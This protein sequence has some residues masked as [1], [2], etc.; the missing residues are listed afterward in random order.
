MSTIGILTIIF[1]CLTCI[2]VVASLLF[3]WKIKNVSLY[4]LISV[5]GAV[6]CLLLNINDFTEITKVLI[7]NS[8]INP[9]KILVFFLS[10][11]ILSITLDNLGFFNFLALKCTRLA[12]NNQFK[13]F[14]IFYLMVSVLTIFT[15]NDIVILA[16]VPFICYFCK[17]SK[18]NPTPYVFSTFVAANTWSMTLVI[19]NPTNVYIA[20]FANL[21][22]VEYF[23]KMALPTL[24]GAI[25][26]LLLMLLLFKKQLKVKIEP[27]E[28]EDLQINK[29]LVI[30]NASLL[31][32]CTV[33]LA[34]SSYIGIEMW[35]VALGFA[36]FEIIINLVICIIKKSDKTYIKNS[37]K[38]A[39]WAFVPFLLSMFLIIMC[40]NSNGVTKYIAQ[41]FE[42]CDSILVYGVSSFLFS[43]LMNNIPMTTLFASILGN[44]SLNL[45]GAYATIVGSNLGALLT[46]VGA[47]AGIMFMKILREKQVDFKIKDFIKYGAIISIASLFTTLGML[48]II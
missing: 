32:T 3:D 43:N 18:I 42:N 6:I 25:V 12:K 22:F 38:R 17:N 23:L 33:L 13:L 7:S 26:S 48:Y 27:T 1:A 41:A 34:I 8:S 10:M 45:A 16:F 24:V 19:G 11:T 30:L 39:P 29:P 46:P 9:L 37:L 44:G 2:A 5:V 14:L 28:Q 47:L 4:Y 21:G 36:V 35:Y 20:S 15:S 40:L 31:G